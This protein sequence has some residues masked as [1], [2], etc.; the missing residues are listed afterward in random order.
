MIACERTVRRCLAME[1]DP[2]YVQIAM[3][4]WAHY[5]GKTPEKVNDV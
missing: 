2:R 3:D 4:R 5:T 1:I